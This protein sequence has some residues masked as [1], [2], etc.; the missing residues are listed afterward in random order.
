MDLQ[1][2]TRPRA[3]NE[4]WLILHKGIPRR[5]SVVEWGADL[6]GQVRDDPNVTGR[7]ACRPPRADSSA[8]PRG[9]QAYRTSGHAGL[10]GR[11]L[12]FKQNVN[13]DGTPARSRE[14]SRIQHCQRQGVGLQTNCRPRADK[15]VGP[16]ADTPNIRACRPAGADKPLGPTR[17]K[18]LQE[19]PFKR[20]N[21]RDLTAASPL[22]RQTCRSPGWQTHRPSG[23][24]HL[25]ALR[26][27]RLKFPSKE[28]ELHHKGT[29]IRGPQSRSIQQCPTSK[30]CHLRAGIAY[31][32][33]EVGKCLPR[34]RQAAGSGTGH[35][36]ITGLRPTGASDM[37]LPA[38]TC[39]AG[40]ADPY[41][42]PRAEYCI[43]VP[44]RGPA[45]GLRRGPS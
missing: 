39:P 6:Q 33:P 18:K 1:G 26:A 38:T 9:Q 5:V 14:N 42:W 22:G 37:D 45:T 17:L 2:P 32:G 28:E 35:K 31:A 40:S 15:A 41:S 34:G 3:D 4:Y 7:Q 11:E 36:T 13:N 20:I 43:R 8:S 12:R 16:R 10:L 30:G 23:P 21:L 24:V 44:A 29:A 25:P 27:G 19:T